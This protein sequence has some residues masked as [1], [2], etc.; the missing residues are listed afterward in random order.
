MLRAMDELTPCKRPAPC[1][2]ETWAIE[3]A[4]AAEA[5]ETTDYAIKLDDGS[6]LEAEDA[7]EAVVLAVVEARG[8]D[9]GLDDIGE[10]CE[11]I[12]AIEAEADVDQA[13]TYADSLEAVAWRYCLAHAAL[14]CIPEELDPAQ[15]EAIVAAAE[16]LVGGS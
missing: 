6:R 7:L 10:A 16:K 15:V 2:T 14:G 4:A 8:A 13:D 1:D 9:L 12:A 11:D 5:A 3:V